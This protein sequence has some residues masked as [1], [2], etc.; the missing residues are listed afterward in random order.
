MISQ[1]NFG[2]TAESINAALDAANPHK[3]RQIEQRFSD[4]YVSIKAAIERGVTRKE[5]L[6]ILASQG[7][8]MCSAKF[9]KLMANE[10]SHRGE[11][12]AQEV[13]P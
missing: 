2:P 12:Q 6:A 10:A 11:T 9:K 7:L 8:K 4:S 13:N 1:S 5:I 3:R